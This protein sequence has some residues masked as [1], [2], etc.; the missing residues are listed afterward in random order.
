M[1]MADPMT[2]FLMLAAGVVWLY[3]AAIFGAQW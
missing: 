1:T 3:V 2:R